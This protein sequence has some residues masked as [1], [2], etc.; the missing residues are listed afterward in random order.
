MKV[1][2]I[3]SG[4]REHAIVWKLS[5]D[6]KI[7]KIYAIPGNAGI[8]LLAECIP[9]K[10]NDIE[11]I[12]NFAKKNKIDWTIVGPEVPLALGIVNLFKKEGLEIWG[13]IKEVARLESSKAF[14]KEIMK[15]AKI[16]TAD[17][18]VFESF[19]DAKIFV[20]KEKFPL[21][22]KADGLAAGKGVFI[23]NNKEEGINILEK[24]IKEKIL[25]D[26]GEKVVIEK[27]LSGKEFSLIAAVKDNSI[28]F[29]PPA[30][31]YKRVG[32]GNTGPNTGGMGSYAP[33]PWISESLI[34]KCK[35][36]IFIPLINELDKRG[37]KY[38]GFLYGGL[39]LVD[40][41]PYVLEFNVR[42]GDPETQVI[43]PLLDF[44]LLT[45][46]EGFKDFK[47]NNKKAVCVVLASKGYPDKYEVE[48]EIK[49][50]NGD[51]SII[52]HAGTTLKNGKLVTSG[53]RVLNIVSIADSFKD[54]KDKVYKKIQ[55]IYFDGIYYRKDI[56]EEVSNF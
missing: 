51:D 27:F 11:E 24:L 47:V 17:F 30:Q 18:K 21:V 26:A 10:V 28:Y 52:F 22:I 44:S 4:G 14:A 6:K 33:V 7:D 2:V 53:G 19:E 12:T 34:D 37:L 32:E 25:G 5:Q 38:E 3:G 39:I 49:I 13:P 36:D 43:L 16:P 20:E 31:D 15:E 23:V 56:A 8:S 35:K 48:K 41:N 45:F 46:T 9:I 40:G 54:A 50:E 29:L 42:L 1:L 55:K